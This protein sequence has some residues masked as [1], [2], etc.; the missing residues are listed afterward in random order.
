VTFDRQA[1]ARS[2]EL[3]SCL[4]E[5]R[6]LRRA[7]RLPEAREAYRRALA[8]APAEAAVLGEMALVEHRLGDVAA[9][10]DLIARA[11]AI[12]PRN[13]DLQ[14]A[15]AALLLDAG[16][17]A[18]AAA[19]LRDVVAGAPEL[20]TAWQRL[21]SALRTLGRHE[22]AGAAYERVIALVPERDDAYNGLG[23]CLEALGRPVEALASYRR[24]VAARPG[25]HQAQ[26]NAGKLLAE[27]G[28][29]AAGMAAQRRALA[30]APGYALAWNDLGICHERLG[31]VDAALDCYTRAAA[32]DPHSALVLN[33]L[34][35]LHFQRG[36]AAPALA[37]LTRAVE[38]DPG[39]VEAQ[40]NLGAVLARMGQLEEAHA[41]HRRAWELDPEQPGTL[42]ALARSCQTTCD[43]ATLAALLPRLEAVARAEVAAG[44]ARPSVSPFTALSLPWPAELQA[45]LSRLA[46]ARI[47]RSMR[48]TRE[49]LALD[50]DRR[51]AGADPERPLR[52][53]YLSAN[54]RNHALAHLMLPVFGLHD[55][56]RFRVYTYSQGEDDGS[57]YRRRIAA[58]SD[59]FRDQRGASH[60][61]IARQI[62]ADGVDV[63]I[64]LHGHTD[65]HRLEVC[66][67]RPAPLVVTYI[68]F[69]ACVGARF[70]DYA[71][72]DAVV[73]PPREAGLY[74]EGLLLMPDSY[75]V[76]D[77]G[78]AI[79]PRPVTRAECG[80][81][82]TA[83]VF[84]CFNG[85][86][87]IDA[88]I[89]ARWMEILRALPESVLWL[90]ADAAPVRANLRREAAAAGVD[91]RRLV[92]A[93]HWPKARHLAR[94]RLAD[95]FLDT[96]LYNA[97]TTA[98][99]ALWAGV[100]VL[101]CPGTT[102]AARVGESLLRAAGLPELVVADLD[103]YVATAVRLGRDRAA[104]AALRETL[105]AQRDRCALF[106]TRRWVRNLER[107][108]RAIWARHAAG[109]P[110]PRVT[111]L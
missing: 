60:A 3:A 42:A 76:T 80:L 40:T 79:D 67:L 47:E 2:D 34:G 48:G 10:R 90:W 9:G 14:V 41:C 73:T 71:V 88:V 74:S 45:G 96:R 32:L 31:E 8:L 104:L 43:W 93:E 49:A 59:V 100:P 29:L 35:N 19:V 77:D 70:V 84:C 37:T 52:I 108:L 72:T 98:C 64:E 50:A 82:E 33:N 51:A 109:E 7:E 16:D 25:N 24:A 6:A 57:E 75:Y 21:G 111:R 65:Q 55:R 97:H 101:T 15:Q 53:G 103:G 5:A 22:E 69:P 4:A 26:R 86:Y 62:H 36:E 110:V 54:F 66:A 106:D 30:L 17:A 58:E 23:V 102:F 91:E 1:R 107:G 78:Q 85:A 99:D 83:A 20:V 56:D 28:D 68:G 39:L 13:C 92:F 46:S 11:L 61:E 27:Q 12:E 38:L 63:L 95:V 89:F 87:K 94:L 18:A 81:P 44:A 105:A